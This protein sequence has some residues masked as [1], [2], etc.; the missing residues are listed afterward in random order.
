MR[1]L[2]KWERKAYEPKTQE[3]YEQFWNEYLPKETRIYDYIL[4][5]RDEKLAGTLKSL[6]DKFE[7]DE[8]TFMGFMDGVNT[9]LVE[10]YDLLKVEADTEIEV[11]IDLEKLYFNMH[12]A[13]ADWLYNLPQWQEIFTEE[14]RKEIV[15][16]YKKSLQAVKEN[17]VG[18]NDPCPCGSGK[19]YKKCCG[20]NA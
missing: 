18:R 20:K 14:K 16:A 7:V 17:T 3:A 9:S 1:L 5:H 13:K 19:K 6:A 10:E 8:L 4:S 15:K 11:N 12:A 2:K